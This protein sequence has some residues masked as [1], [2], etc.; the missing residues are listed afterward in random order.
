VIISTE[1]P[2]ILFSI[3]KM[4][5]SIMDDALS[6]FFDEEKARENA[7]KVQA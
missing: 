1:P 3:N 2:F 7:K 6:D 4:G 5:T